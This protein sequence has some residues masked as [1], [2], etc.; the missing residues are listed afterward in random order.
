VDVC[1]R[2]RQE[3]DQHRVLLIDEINRG[4]VAAVLGELIT[5]LEA[6][7]RGS[8]SAVL[9]ISRRA[10]TVPANLWVIGTMNTAD[11]SIS[12]LD[13]ALRR[14]FGF[15]ELLPEPERV[16]VMVDGLSLSALLA[17]INARVRKYVT[18]NA[19]E[20]QV[21]HAYLM[22]AGHPLATRS[23]VHAAFRD[24]I[25]PLLAEYC[26]ENYAALAK[27]VG[28]EIID[29]AAQVPRAAV[30]DDAD[31]LHKALLQLVGADPTRDTELG[32][33]E[34]EDANASTDDE[35]QE[36]SEDT[37]DAVVTD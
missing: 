29:V 30:M 13:A 15:V 24:D 11:R 35:V 34:E 26:F 37:D 27:I 14:R 23:E 25:L 4:N 28:D 33:D 32:G 18:R 7:K 2:A 9:P 10:F 6:D 20:L 21:G 5:L 1:E 16:A 8:V 31:R 17:E 3:P 19:R 22:R 12:L 36:D